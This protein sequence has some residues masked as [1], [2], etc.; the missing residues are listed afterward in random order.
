MQESRIKRLFVM[1]DPHFSHPGICRFLRGD[2]TKLRPWDDPAEMDEYMVGAWNETVRPH[3]QVYVLGDV[4]MKE[5][6]LPILHR[7]HGTKVLVKGNH[8]IFE[9]RKYAPYFKDIRAYHRLSNIWMSHI[10]IHPESVGRVIANVHGH[11]HDRVVRLPDGTEDL[12]YICVSAEH[13]DYRPVLWDEVVERA[14][15]RTQQEV[16]V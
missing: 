10:P 11:I 2:G 3:D 15:Q 6:F 9:M 1:A 5:K 4:V 14:K 13:T 7:L 16:T 12:R 8:D